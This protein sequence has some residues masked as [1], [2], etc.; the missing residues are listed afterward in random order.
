MN[1]KKKPNILKGA[2]KSKNRLRESTN[3]PLDVPIYV[4]AG[5]MDFAHSNPVNPP[6]KE[7]GKQK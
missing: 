1:R 2:G 3:S 5:M 7:G 6:K 4:K